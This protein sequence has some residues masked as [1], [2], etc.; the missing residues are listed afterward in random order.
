MTDKIQ[1]EFR[2][3]SSD[4]RP[5]SVKTREEASVEF[6]NFHNMIWTSI[7]GLVNSVKRK[8]NGGSLDTFNRLLFN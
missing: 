4:D 3:A 6:V 5:C 2:A 7:I 1:F 8:S